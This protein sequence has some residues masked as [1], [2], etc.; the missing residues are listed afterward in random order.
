M[1]KDAIT[2]NAICPG[3]VRTLTNEP[4]MAHDA[5][6]LGKSIAEYEVTMTPLSRRLE[7]EEIAPL[8]LYL[9]SDEA[10][11][12]TGQYFNIDGGV[13]MW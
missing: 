2:V 4:R 9:A 3:A 12:V 5:K 13:F 6:R 11:V 10:L 1:V 8:A 7:S